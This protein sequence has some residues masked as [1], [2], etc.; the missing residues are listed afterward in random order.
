MAS[1]RASKYVISRIDT[2]HD[3][4]RIGFRAGL[5]EA[6]SFS[7]ALLSL[8]FQLFYLSLAEQIVLEEYG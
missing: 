7:H 4:G 8:L 1:R 6:D 3:A 5:A 2:L